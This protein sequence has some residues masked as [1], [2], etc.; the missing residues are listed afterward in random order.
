MGVGRES[1]ELQVFLWKDLVFW[2]SSKVPRAKESVK[3]VL[4]WAALAEA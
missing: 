1:R 2:A 4:T 3:G